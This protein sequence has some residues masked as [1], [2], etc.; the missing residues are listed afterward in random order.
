VLAAQALEMADDQATLA[1]LSQHSL[2]ID[3]LE[4][5]RH[6]SE[7]RYAECAWSL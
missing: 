6:E 5:A 4:L 3:A 1:E 7:R 2:K